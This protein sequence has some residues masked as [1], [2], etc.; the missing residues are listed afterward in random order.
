MSKSINELSNE[1]KMLLIARDFDIKNDKNDKF[2][3]DYEIKRA[4]N[5]INRCRR[6]TPNDDNLYDTK[7]E[8]LI[9]PLAVSSFAKIG[10][11]GQTRHSENGI[12][13]SYSSGGDY[14]K[15]ITNGI[16]PLI[17]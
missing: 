15:D 14:P 5:E 13:R 4:I 1:L 2:I 8:D 3:L 12:T 6:F 11:E 17:K 9:L 16:I 10:A 7:Y